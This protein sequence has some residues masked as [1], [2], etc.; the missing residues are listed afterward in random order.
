MA[1]E[2]QSE[3]LWVEKVTSTG[4]AEQGADSSLLMVWVGVDPSPGEQGIITYQLAGLF[5]GKLLKRMLKTE[6]FVVKKTRMMIGSGM[7]ELLKLSGEGYGLE[8]S[9]MEVLHKIF[10]SVHRNMR[11]ANGWESH[12]FK[13]E[14]K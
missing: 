14:N 9:G 7:T 11:G 13:P 2:N 8:M 4:R 6:L 5:C 3:N 12:K 10:I 1:G